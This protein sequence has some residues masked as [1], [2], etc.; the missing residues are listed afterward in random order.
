MIKH[1]RVQS[2]IVSRESKI[3]FKMYCSSEQ[4][5][6]QEKKPSMS[7][8]VVALQPSRGCQAS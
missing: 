4:N 2:F 3:K 1:E 8:V 6:P 5:T 7:V